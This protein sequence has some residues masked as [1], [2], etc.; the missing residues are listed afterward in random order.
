MFNKYEWVDKAKAEL[1]ELAKGNC[2]EDELDEALYHLIDTAVIYYSDCWDIARE[3][4]MTDWS[5][6][7]YPVKN[8]T[9]LAAYALREYASGA[10]DIQEIIEEAENV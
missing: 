4:N 10:I 8:I 7:D 5:E 1:L 9:Q 2:S 3:F 6:L